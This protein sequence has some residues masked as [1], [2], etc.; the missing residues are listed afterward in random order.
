MWRRQIHGRNDDHCEWWPNKCRHTVTVIIERKYCKIH[1][2]KKM[3]TQRFKWENAPAS[4]GAAIVHIGQ[5]YNEYNS[6]NNLLKGLNTVFSL[7]WICACDHNG[8]R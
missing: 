8:F 7:Q 1:E 3:L 2:W 5:F 4:D 6:T